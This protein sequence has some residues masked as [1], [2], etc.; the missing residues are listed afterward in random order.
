MKYFTNRLQI[1]K[2]FYAR[3][4][5]LRIIKSCFH[6]SVHRW[7]VH[8]VLIAALRVR[9]EAAVYRHMA[10]AQTE[11]AVFKKACLKPIPKEGAF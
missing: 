5:N 4:A 2:R 10:A 11:C 8:Q 1:W 6:R 7:E 3:D 9:M